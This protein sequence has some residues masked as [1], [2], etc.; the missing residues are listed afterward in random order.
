MNKNSYNQ[1]DEIYI[2]NL[3]NVEAITDQFL[4]DMRYS[5][6]NNFACKKVYSMSLCILQ[7]NT[8]KKLIKANE[9]FLKMGLRIKIWDAYRPLS[10]QKFFFDLI[11]NEDF[12]ANPYKGQGSVHSSGFAVDITLVDMNG[13]EIEMP[14][15]FD[16]FTNKASRNS[17]E[18]TKK[19]S[20][21]LSIL[22]EILTEN[23]FDTIESEWWHYKDTDAKTFT[24]LNFSFE[25]ILNRLD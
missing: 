25:E 7:K 10:T 8:L 22:T 18:M 4:I 15:D 13:E 20:K 6:K 3:V 19:A 23:G 21:N 17:T 5:T 12:V 9:K 11:Q 14:T 16:D 24:P 2:S 1:N